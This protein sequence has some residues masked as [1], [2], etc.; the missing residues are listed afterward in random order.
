M[1]GLD[2]N[3]ADLERKTDP[4]VADETLHTKIPRK[5]SPKSNVQKHSVPSEIKLTRL[6][7]K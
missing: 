6:Y 1:G 7:A 3:K 5:V 2:G 4:I